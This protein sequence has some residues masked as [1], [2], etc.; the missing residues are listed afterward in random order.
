MSVVYERPKSIQP[1]ASSYCPGCLHATATKIIAEVID[2]LGKKDEAIYVL[3]VGCSTQGIVSWDLDIIGAA[4]GRAPAVATGIKRCRPDC[5]VF[6]YQGDGDL[7]SIGLAEILSA[8]NRGENITVIYANNSIFGMTGGQMAP[9]TLLGQKATTARE[10]R[11]LLGTGYPLKMCELV[12]ELEAPRLVQRCTLRTP[13]GIRQAKA[14][15]MKGFENQ[16]A[17]KGF[18]F[19]ELLTNCPTTW[20]M[21]PLES[22]DFME[23]QTEKYFPCGVFADREGRFG[24]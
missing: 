16:L 4:H 2:A 3:P 21:S 15:I 13:G 8:A 1:N 17:G 10:G 12:K 6:C 11:Q 18:S 20:H 23:Q 9:T 19:I 22:L 24:A 14:A 7:A 5:L